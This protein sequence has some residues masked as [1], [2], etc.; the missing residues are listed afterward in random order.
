MYFIPS[1]QNIVNKDIVK[2]H[3]KHD[4]IHTLRETRVVVVNRQQVKSKQTL[5]AK[6]S[7]LVG[8]TTRPASVEYDDGARAEASELVLIADD[9]VNCHFVVRVQLHL[10]TYVNH[11]AWKEHLINNIIRKSFLA[12]QYCLAL[13]LI[14][15][16]WNCRL[17]GS[18]N[19]YNK[20]WCLAGNK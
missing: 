17:D 1:S 20:R 18:I 10:V 3:S 4:K 2:E 13:W 14:L 7:L 11:S 8:P 16:I 5:Q 12:T 19:T 6:H 9:V 15:C